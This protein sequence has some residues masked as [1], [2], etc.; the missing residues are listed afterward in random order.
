MF[1]LA[2]LHRKYERLDEAAR[3]KA[4]QLNSRKNTTQNELD[5]FTIPT[6]VELTA[7]NDEITRTKSRQLIRTANRLGLPV[8]EGDESW[9]SSFHGK[10]GKHLTVAAQV[11]LR[12]AIRQEQKELREKWMGMVKDVV[13]PLG[14]IVISILSLLIAYSALHMKH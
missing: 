9:T 1:R 2:L 10:F 5:A 7:V 12:Q 6:W 11:E 4:L 14:G 3:Q 13:V 8:P